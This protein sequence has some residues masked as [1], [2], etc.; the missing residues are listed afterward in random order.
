MVRRILKVIE[1]LMKRKIGLGVILILVL[2]C[3]AYLL[4]SHMNFEKVVKRK[5]NAER[6]TKYPGGERAVPN[7]AYPWVARLRATKINPHMTEDDTV[8]EYGVRFGWNIALVKAK[9]RIGFDHFEFAPVVREHG[10]EFIQDLTTIPDDTIDVVVCHHQLEHT[11][12]PV[13]VL[14]EIRRILRPKGK[15]LLFVPYEKGKRTRGYDPNDSLHRL[16]SWNVQT[17]GNLVETNG[18]KVIGGKIGKFGYDRFCGV[19]A[20]R[21]QLGE[22]GFRA[23]RRVAHLVKHKFEVEIVAEKK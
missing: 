2:I 7:S 10:I 4:L 20:S 6:E 16:Y 1:V 21:Y 22:L 12:T 23:L 8:L 3:F 13:K 5:D 18:F 19:L 9:R 15:L 17:L 11:L 14:D